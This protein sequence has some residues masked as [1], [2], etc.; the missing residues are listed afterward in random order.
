MNPIT[1][2]L[3]GWVV[4]NAPGLERRERAA[5]AIAGVIPDFDGL[6]VVADFLTRHSAHPTNW[7]GEYHHIL[8]HNITFAVAVAAAAFF[9]ARQKWKTAALAFLCVHLH[10]LGDLVGAR[11]PEGEQWAIPYLNPFTD[12]VQLVW[13]GQWALNAWPNF[14]ITFALLAA[15]FY[16]A[17]ARGFSPL[18]LLSRRADAA[19][20]DSLRRRFP[21]AR[22]IS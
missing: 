6:G 18:E 10:I 22:Q 21:L 19:F 13:S 14:A 7:W 2:F 4:A 11:G 9:L 20:V 17:R 16:L 12:S 1:H 8:G 5:V 3:A 15:T